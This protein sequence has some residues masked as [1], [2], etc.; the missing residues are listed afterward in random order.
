M[1]STPEDAELPF[2]EAAGGDKAA[3]DRLF[4]SLYDDLKSVA[5]RQIRRKEQN[6]TVGPTAAVNLLYEK[7]VRS[8]RVTAQ[9]RAEFLV[10]AAVA[11]QRIVIDHYRRKKVRD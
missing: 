10:A 1:T 5:A 8:G 7:W 4:V 2:L 6:P 9:N 11:M 3:A